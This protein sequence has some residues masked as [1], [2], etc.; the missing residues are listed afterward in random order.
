MI[1]SAQHFNREISTKNILVAY[2]IGKREANIQA[3]VNQDLYSSDYVAYAVFFACQYQC[4]ML[5][6]T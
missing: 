4:Q 3:Y 6:N 1:I 2:R 5:E